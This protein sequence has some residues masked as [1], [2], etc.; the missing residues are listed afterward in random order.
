M[1]LSS[2]NYEH[3]NETDEGIFGNRIIILKRVK[4]LKNL[5]RTE[6]ELVRLNYKEAIIRGF[7]LKGIQQYIAT[8]TKI[9]IEWYC[10]ETLKKV[11][12]QENREWYYHMAKDHFAYIGAHRKCIDEIEQLKK[13]MWKIIMD[14]KAEMHVRVQATKELH[15]LAKTS[16]LLLRDLPFVANLSKLYDENTLNSIY[17]NDSLQSNNEHLFGNIQEVARDYIQRNHHK[18][19]ENQDN[20]FDFNGVNGE[21]TLADES[22]SNAENK[23]QGKY[24]RL[25]RDVIEDM[26][27]QMHITDPLKDKSIEEITDEDLDKI[28]TPQHKESIKKIQE[29]LDD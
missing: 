10:M 14:T 29:L 6:R 4:S 3:S 21:K 23:P 15:S 19:P 26:Q 27:R 11:E 17:N 12:E 2:K 18:K 25:D 9:W 7:T 16:A 5:R 22:R 20:P 24:K 1:A 28:I 8:K 13:E